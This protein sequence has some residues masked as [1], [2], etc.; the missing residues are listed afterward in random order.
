VRVTGCLPIVDRLGQC[1]TAVMR[2]RRRTLL[3]GLLAVVLVG[4]P[5]T[6]FLWN[7]VP[8]MRYI[9]RSRRIINQKIIALEGRRP[10]NVAPELWSE[11]VAWASIAYCNTCFSEEHASYQA[12]CRFE[13]QLDEKL[14]GDVDLTTFVW[15]ADRLA[16]TGPRGKEYISRWREQLNRSLQ[17]AGQKK[18]P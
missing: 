12:M 1:Y 3:L 10:A 8:M 4:G 15:I 2:I 18:I 6:W 13:Q 5:L 9:Q 17:Q 7:A 16:E 14:K 11:C